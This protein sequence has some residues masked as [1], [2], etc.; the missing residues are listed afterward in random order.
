MCTQLLLQNVMAFVDQSYF[1]QAHF[2]LVEV[3]V[4]IELPINLACKQ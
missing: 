3:M 4:E 2:N 1:A